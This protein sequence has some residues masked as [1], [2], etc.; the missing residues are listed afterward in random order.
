MYDADASCADCS[1]DDIVTTPCV[2]SITVINQIQEHF[3]DHSSGT[4]FMINVALDLFKEIK[5]FRTLT[6]REVSL[7]PE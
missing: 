4:H 7:S 1:E 3:K 6:V 5:I 2:V